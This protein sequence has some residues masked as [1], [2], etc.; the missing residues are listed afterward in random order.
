MDRQDMMRIG[1][2]DSGSDLVN[3]VVE[4]PTGS[5]SKFKY[6]EERALFWLYKILPAGRL[7]FE[8]GFIP[9]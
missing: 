6:H 7:P 9:H 2:R 5:R 1:A 3:V 8:F 4:S